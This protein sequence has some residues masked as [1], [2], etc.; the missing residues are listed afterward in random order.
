LEL[1]MLKLFCILNDNTYCDFLEKQLELFLSNATILEDKRLSCMLVTCIQHYLSSADSNLVAVRCRKFLSH[2]SF[3][4]FSLLFVS[5]MTTLPSSFIFHLSQDV[6]FREKVLSTLRNLVKQR[7]FSRADEKEFLRTFL[8]VWMEYDCP[9]SEPHLLLETLLENVEIFKSD[10][11]LT[12]KCLLLLVKDASEQH[13]MAEVWVLVIFEYLSVLKDCFFDCIWNHLETR[14]SSDALNRFNSQLCLKWM[15]LWEKT[16]DEEDIVNFAR[17]YRASFTSTQFSPDTLKD[18]CSFL[19]ELKEVLSE[20]NRLR[21]NEI[22]LFIRNLLSPQVLKVFSYVGVERL[23]EFLGCVLSCVESEAFQDLFVSLR[24]FFELVSHDELEDI[25]F[26]I[27]RLACE[28]LDVEVEDMSPL[29]SLQETIASTLEILSSSSNKNGRKISFGLIEKEAFLLDDFSFF[30]LV[31]ISSL[32]IETYQSELLQLTLESLLKEL[33]LLYN[34]DDPN[35]IL[36][37]PESSNA[38]LRTV[39]LCKRIILSNPQAL[40][41]QWAH[42]AVDIVRGLKQ[43]EMNRS[44]QHE[45]TLDF[46]WNRA[47][48]GYI[49]HA[50]DG[51]FSFAL[52]REEILCDANLVGFIRNI[53]EGALEEMHNLLVAS[54]TVDVDYFVVS[55]ASCSLLLQLDSLQTSTTGNIP[56]CDMQLPDKFY[57]YALESLLH[58][59]IHEPSLQME[60]RIISVAKLARKYS[61]LNEDL[62]LS[63]QCYNLLRSLNQELRLTGYSLLAG[64]DPRY[65]VADICHSEDETISGF[66]EETEKLLAFPLDTSWLGEVDET[67]KTAIVSSE[68]LGSQTSQLLGY[69]L[70]W[71][72]LLNYKSRGDPEFNRILSEY[73]R[74]HF[75]LFNDFIS[76]VAEWSVFGA[77]NVSKELQKVAADSA[78]ASCTEM[79]LNV[80][81]LLLQPVYVSMSSVSWVITTNCY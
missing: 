31:H 18:M 44:Q 1:R 21:R 4:F 26:H 56:E 48:L 23:G 64:L 32:N 75:Y 77:T 45:N 41:D 80:S 12:R 57:L 71:V 66:I 54:E 20:D 55:C 42:Y 61:S 38:R 16:L 22:L 33:V 68:F 25:V 40:R 6:E 11:E 34:S 78:S 67:L 35:S 74:E 27:F 73:L 62:S 36:V 15:L 76:F 13:E 3:S 43:V 59:F 72:L 29:H 63:L 46:F 49:F 65:L 2:C 19:V 28:R 10:V 81:E 5:L 70:T 69:L 51:L 47:E 37:R 79:E 39:L 30:V 60:S 8:T 14:W 9:F 50:M 17:L 52:G 58:V 24:Q 7:A 53:A